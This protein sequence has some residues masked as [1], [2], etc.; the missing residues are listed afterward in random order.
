VRAVAALGGKYEDPGEG[1]TS[2]KLQRIAAGQII[3]GGLKISASWERGDI[4]GRWS[5]GKRSVDA[6]LRQ[7]GRAVVRAEIRHVPGVTVH[8]VCA[9]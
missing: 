2:L 9:G 8:I 3:Q 4:S 6:S 1:R 7:G 5:I